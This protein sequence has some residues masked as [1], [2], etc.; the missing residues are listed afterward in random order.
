MISCITGSVV[1]REE[2]L[3][4]GVDLLHDAHE[5]HVDVQ[6]RQLQLVDQP[7]HLLEAYEALL[8]YLLS[9]IAIVY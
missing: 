7:V 2:L 6:G 1:L 4:R 8:S 9:Y 5:P 3:V